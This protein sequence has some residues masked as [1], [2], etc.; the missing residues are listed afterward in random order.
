[1]SS[2]GSFLRF[3]RQD[4]LY[5]LDGKEG[6]FRKCLTRIPIKLTSPK[7]PDLR[8]VLAVR[9]EHGGNGRWREFFDPAL[10]LT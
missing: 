3:Y 6:N 2:Y 8:P 9:V 1:M 10:F 7:T 4:A 5:A